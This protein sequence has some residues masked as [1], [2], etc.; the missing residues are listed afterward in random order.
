MDAVT[1]LPDSLFAC[2]V[3][4]HA[5]QEIRPGKMS[6]GPLRPRSSL[7]CTCLLSR[8]HFLTMVHQNRHTGFCGQRCRRRQTEMRSGLFRN[9]CLVWSATGVVLMVSG[10]SSVSR[11]EVGFSKGAP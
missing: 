8:D 1:S 6:C 4:I 10:S 11:L 3:N 7:S 5:A 2:N 9:D